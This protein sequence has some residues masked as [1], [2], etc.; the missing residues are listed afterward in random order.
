MMTRSRRTLRKFFEFIS[1]LKVKHN[2]N[3]KQTKDISADFI[4]YFSQTSHSVEEFTKLIP[5]V[6]SQHLQNKYLIEEYGV[7]QTKSIK[8]QNDYGYYIPLSESLKYDFKSKDFCKRFFEKIDQR[9][10]NTQS[11]RDFRDGLNYK[12]KSSDYNTI[13]LELYIDDL[14]LSS[15]IGYGKCNTKVFAMYYTVKN[16]DYK[17]SAER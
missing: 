12:N 11:Y 10:P 3:E 17:Y 9:R 5:F 14:T 15:P 13:F 7:P 2:L 8:F 16:I 6:K 1:G 4:S